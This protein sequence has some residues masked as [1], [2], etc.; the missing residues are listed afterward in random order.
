MLILQSYVLSFFKYFDKYV[1]TDIGLSLMGISQ[2]PIKSL[3][4]FK[5]FLIVRKDAV[6]YAFIYIYVTFE[7]RGASKNFNNF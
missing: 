1:R 3:Y 7:R 5:D 6:T 4:Y 2:S